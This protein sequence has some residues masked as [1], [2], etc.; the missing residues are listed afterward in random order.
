MKM[1]HYK[2]HPS[3]LKSLNLL[4]QIQ[5][6][7]CM[8]NKPKKSL[9]TIPKTHTT[10]VLRKMQKHP[11]QPPLKFKFLHGTKDHANTNVKHKETY[12]RITIRNFVIP[13]GNHN[14]FLTRLP[15]K[16]SLH[17]MPYWQLK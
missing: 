15:I 14:L 9:T 6:P 1:L 4:N 5:K 13:N 12:G 11:L 8:T 7:K 3:T 17:S 10:H 2:Y 16:I